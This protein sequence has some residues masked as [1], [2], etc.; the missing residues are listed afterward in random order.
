MRMTK[1]EIAL[2]AGTVAIVAAVLLSGSWLSQHS[3]GGRAGR[4]RLTYRAKITGVVTP[5]DI[6]EAGFMTNPDIV[7]EA[8]GHWFRDYGSPPQ[9][10]GTYTIQGDEI[11]FFNPPDPNLGPYQPLAGQTGEL[12]KDGITL[13]RVSSGP[14]DYLPSGRSLS[15]SSK[16]N[17]L[18]IRIE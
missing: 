6:T 9:V 11:T 16:Y 5:V 7:L 3:A 1:R 12:F 2:L 8:G 10:K 4:Y 18:Y 13:R 15:G 14:Q 17:P